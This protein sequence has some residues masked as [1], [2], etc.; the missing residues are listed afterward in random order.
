MATTSRYVLAIPFAVASAAAILAG[1][2]GGGDS[3]SPPSP[4]PVA[5]TCDE[6]MKAAFKPDVNTT[7]T[8]VKLFKAGSQVTLPGPGA[9]PPIFVTAPPVA[10]FDLCM[11]KLVVGP[12]TAG[13]ASA[14]STSPG[15]GIEA[16]LPAVASWDRR[17][18]V[19]GTGGNGPAAGVLLADSIGAPEAMYIALSHGAATAQTDHGHATGSSDFLMMPDGTIN[20]Q[21][22]ENWGHRAVHET[23]LKLKALVTAFYGT[24]ASKSYFQGCSG[25][26]RDAYSAA[27][28]HPEDFDG[29]VAGAPARSWSR[30]Q[31][32]TTYNPLVVWRDLG[33]V[34]PT[35]AQQASVTAAAVN[36]CDASLNGQHDGFITD[37]D[38]CHYDPTKDPG[39]LCTADGGT[40]ATAACVSKIQ[41]QVFNKIW[42]G[43]TVDGSVPDPQFDLGVG[44]VI[45]PKQLYP[46]VARGTA[47]PIDTSPDFSD[48]AVVLNMPS[49][50][51]PDFHNAT[52]DGQDGW[53][54][55][56]YPQL[57]NYVY[58]SISLQSYLGYSDADNPDLT[59][60]RDRGGKLLA[61]HGM[62]DTLIPHNNTVDYYSRSSDLSGG[63]A[64]TSKFHRLYLIPGQEHCGSIGFYPSSPNLPTLEAE[65]GEKTFTGVGTGGLVPKTLFDAM[66]DWVEKGTPPPDAIVANN[67]TN[68]NSRPICAYPKKATYI[69]GNVDVASSYGCR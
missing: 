17:I 13:P 12:A 34:F 23:A 9:Q 64:E 57:A 60:Y 31:G 42:Y 22:A 8:A 21:G 20:T 16:W 39:V 30:F 27:Q 49:L 48:F 43:Q 7:V 44:R 54:N 40:N 41:A 11:V 5:L 14:P 45:G 62:G 46:G 47:M 25:G 69:G 51:K 63:Y 61:Y 15:I 53:R 67:P 38:S 26:G 56:T 55:L 50:G 58:Q 1:C 68:T 2:D 10:P 4:Q 6:S 19:L 29:I 28:M 36:A 18:R 33:G 32:Y 52:G 3:G 37:P 59:K 65:H 35:A 66:V 24:G